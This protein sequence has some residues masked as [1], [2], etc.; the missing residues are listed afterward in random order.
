MHRSS[1]IFAVLSLAVAVGCGG[2]NSGTIPPP[3]PPADQYFKEHQATTVTTN[4]KILLDTVTE[5][6]GK[7]EYCTEDGSYWR[8]GYS[9][10]AD[11][12]YQYGTPDS[13]PI[14]AAESKP[15]PD[16]IPPR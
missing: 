12:T 6:D 14:P 7:I 11:G 4:G 5:R 15:P 9:K 10:R 13:I 1:R 3:E 2:D 16:S 8:V